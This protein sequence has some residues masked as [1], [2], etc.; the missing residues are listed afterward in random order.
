MS[1]M[2]AERTSA[3]SPTPVPATLDR[4]NRH[5]AMYSGV[6]VTCLGRHMRMEMCGIVDGSQLPQ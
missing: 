1:A 4:V 6:L 5:I 3:I 2:N